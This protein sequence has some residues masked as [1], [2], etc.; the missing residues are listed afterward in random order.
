VRYRPNQFNQ[1]IE[2]RYIRYA[3]SRKERRPWLRADR[4]RIESIDTSQRFVFGNLK[5]RLSNVGNSPAAKVFVDA[6]YFDFDKINEAIQFA[7]AHEPNWGDF[8]KVI[9]AKDGASMILILS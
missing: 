7:K 5:V 6:A 2:T 3:V 1:A 4:F 9:F 8:G